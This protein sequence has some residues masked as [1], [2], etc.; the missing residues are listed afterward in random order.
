MTLFDVSR[1]RVGRAGE[2]ALP[3]ALP[4]NHLTDRQRAR[5]DRAS[6][7]PSTPGRRRRRRRG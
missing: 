1:Q 6:A 2:V 5:V 7:L 4:E 3:E